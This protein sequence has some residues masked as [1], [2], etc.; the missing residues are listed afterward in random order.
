[1]LVEAD[2]APYALPDPAPDDIDRAIAER[3][4]SFITDGAT[5]QIGIGAVPNMVA[6]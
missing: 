2:G 3:A 5:L 4:R 6:S 1:M